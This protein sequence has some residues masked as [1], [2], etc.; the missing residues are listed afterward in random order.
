MLHELI[1]RVAD[2]DHERISSCH[3]IVKTRVF[4]T[5]FPGSIVRLRAV[6]RL[7]V[8]TPRGVTRLACALSVILLELSE[9][10]D[11]R[12]EYGV[13]VGARRGS[14]NFFAMAFHGM[15]T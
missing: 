7:C 5:R 3:G 12:E 15:I 9:Y 8:S 1:E 2:R 4:E 6:L 14:C 13:S 10:L 11:N